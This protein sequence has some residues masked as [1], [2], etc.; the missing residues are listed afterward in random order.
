KQDVVLEAMRKYGID[1]N[2]PNPVLS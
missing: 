1:R 2:K